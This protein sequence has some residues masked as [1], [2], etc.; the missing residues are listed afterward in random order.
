[1]KIEID[2]TNKT[3]KITEVISLSHL[4]EDLK[5]ILPEDKW[6]E[7]KIIP[8]FVNLIPSNQPVWIEPYTLKVISTTPDTNYE[9]LEKTHY[10]TPNH[11]LEYWKSPELEKSLQESGWIEKTTDLRGDLF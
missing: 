9:H 5:Q 1:M 4:L 7:Y 6:N 8:S 2:T 10:L 11:M 3:I